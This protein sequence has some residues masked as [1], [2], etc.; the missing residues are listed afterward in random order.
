MTIR[1]IQINLKCATDNPQMLLAEEDLYI[2]LVK[3]AGVISLKV[4]EFPSIKN[5]AKPKF[6]FPKK[7]I[8]IFSLFSA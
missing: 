1:I 4:K 6:I 2:A 3:Q 7:Q 5:S 8:N